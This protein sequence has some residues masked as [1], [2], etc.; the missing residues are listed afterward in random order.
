ML[1]SHCQHLGESCDTSLTLAITLGP[2]KDCPGLLYPKQLVLKLCA[3]VAVEV[4][5][6]AI[7]FEDMLM[8]AL[9]IDMASWFGIRKASMNLVKQ[10]VG[11]RIYLW[12]CRVSVSE[13]GSDNANRHS[14]REGLLGGQLDFC[15]V[16]VSNKASN[17]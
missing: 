17:R 6:V 1:S 9:A 2:D 12:P 16:H 8:R 13:K 4:G 5:C 7:L 15:L 3:I 14:F 10:S 11:T